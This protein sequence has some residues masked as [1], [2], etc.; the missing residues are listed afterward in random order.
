MRVLRRCSSQN[1][2]F[3]YVVNRMYSNIKDLPTTN[4]TEIDVAKYGV[5]Y[6]DI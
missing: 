4:G 1:L 5:K 2:S 3:F 6:G